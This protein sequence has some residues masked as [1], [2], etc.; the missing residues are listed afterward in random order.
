MSGA[1]LRVLEPCRPRLEEPHHAGPGGASRLVGDSRCMRRLRELIGQVAR[2]P[3]STVLIT[4]ESGT[5]K[6]LV[7][8]AIHAGSARS[9]APFVNI[10]CSALPE[11]LLESEL[12]G[13]ERGAFTDA[14]ERRLGLLEQANG[15]TVF[16]DEIA[17]VPPAVQ[18]KLLRFLEER[19]F[20]RVGGSAELRPDLRVIAATHQDLQ[21]RIA[22]GAFRADL[23]YRLAV[24]E[25]RAPPLRERQGD[26]EL[27]A[28]T[29]L[30][31]FAREL[32]RPVQ[33]LTPAALRT[34]ERH[35][36]PGNVRELKNA[37]ERGVLLARGTTL[38]AGDFELTADPVQPQ[39]F[40]LPPGGLDLEALERDLLR[41][42]LERAGGNQ[43]RAARLLGLTRDQ[44]RYRLAK[45]EP[46]SPA[47][48]RAIARPSGSVDPREAT[49]GS[50]GS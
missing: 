39:R 28:R 3:A 8:R 47:R 20:R 43:T 25:L 9:R 29:V 27:L 30:A 35:P 48:R 38:D 33:D 10:T 32:E 14:R 2:S 36:W 41:Q 42:A 11:T 24:L 6:D 49:C 19:A 50:P 44:V 31:R 13:H 23:Y 40:E 12:F 34:L 5:G 1:R 4:G 46:G 37:L 18:A 45:L 7:A 15:G 22:S 26:V 16:L 17:E 21:A